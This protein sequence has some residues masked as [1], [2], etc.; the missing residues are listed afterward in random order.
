M[1]V[2]DQ[3]ED[4]LPGRTTAT[5]GSSTSRAETTVRAAGLRGE[6][7]MADREDPA[8]FGGESPQ[9]RS[10]WMCGIRMPVG[11]MVAD[12]GSACQD[13]RW[14]CRDTWGCTQRWTSHPPRLTAIRPDVADTE[15]PGEQV[16]SPGASRPMP[17]MTA[18]GP[19]SGKP[20]LCDLSQLR[21][22]VSRTA[23]L[24]RRAQ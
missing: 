24:V 1:K 15:P 12:G 23:V 2:G 9:V 8:S 7:V 22:A 21:W 19:G 6:Q 14:Y 18:L 13:V 11:R 17:A 3:L 4:R 16:A 10:C 20:A 5:V